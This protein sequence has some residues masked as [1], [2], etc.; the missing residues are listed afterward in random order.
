MKQEEIR[1]DD[2]YRPS[3]GLETDNVRLRGIGLE[4]FRSGRF[5]LQARLFER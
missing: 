1:S 5:L 4:A 2:G 3:F